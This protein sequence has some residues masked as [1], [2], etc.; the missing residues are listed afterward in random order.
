MPIYEFTIYQT[1]VVESENEESGRKAVEGVIE[2]LDWRDYGIE[3]LSEITTQEGFPDGWD[4][5]CLPYGGDGE[6]R[7]KDLL[8]K[9]KD[10]LITK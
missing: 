1:L 4:G 9:A 3:L 5:N 7:L 2:D 10:P 6:T 8:P